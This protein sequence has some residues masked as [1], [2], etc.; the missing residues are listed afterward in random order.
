MHIVI[1]TREQKKL[2]FKEGKVITGITEK[3]LDAGDYSLLGH[4]N[5]IAFERKSAGD[6]YATLGKGHGRF[7]KELE[8]A[9]DYDYF[10]III[11]ESYS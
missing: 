9:K 7:K 10:A 3:K 4:E 6:L 11:E 1:D 8:R 5:K 2:P